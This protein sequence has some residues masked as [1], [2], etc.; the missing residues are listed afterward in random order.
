[1]AKPS[2]IEVNTNKALPEP[3]LA[4]RPGTSGT[5]LGLRTERRK[6][7]SALQKAQRAE[8]AYRARKQ[9]TSARAHMS[10]AKAHFKASFKSAKIGTVFFWSGVKALPGVWGEK[11]SAMREKREVKK[12]VQQ[13]EKRK[14]L[15][16]KMKREEE[17]ASAVE[18]DTSTIA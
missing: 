9:A 18:G 11:R 13:A 5:E 17:K 3:E 14:K 16:E 15:E 7:S 2:K 8:Q 4:Q 6:A 12:R 10:A 1:M